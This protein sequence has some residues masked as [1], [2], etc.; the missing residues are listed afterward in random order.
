[1]GLSKLFPLSLL[2]SKARV[3]PHCIK[4]A[5]MPWLE[6]SHSTMDIFVKLGVTR[7]RVVHVASLSSSHDMIA[8]LVKENVSLFNNFVRGAIIDHNS[9]QIYG[10]N[11]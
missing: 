3:L 4:F 11:L 8:Y 2:L 9:S 5:P 10:N 6:A 7:M 1:M